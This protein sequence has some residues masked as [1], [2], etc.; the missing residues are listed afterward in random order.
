MCLMKKRYSFETLVIPFSSQQGDSF[1]GACCLITRGRSRISFS[2]TEVESDT[3]SIS[4]FPLV[5]FVPLLC[6]L[7][8][9]FLG[10]NSTVCVCYVL[11]CLSSHIAMCHIVFLFCLSLYLSAVISF[12][13][14]HLSM[15]LIIGALHEV[16][17]H[18]ESVCVCVGGALD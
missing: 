10:E 12:I 13:F 5:S 6:L 3:G 14:P 7:F 17:S 1:F 15:P 8:H 2:F 18:S 11:F 9:P 4:F 16:L